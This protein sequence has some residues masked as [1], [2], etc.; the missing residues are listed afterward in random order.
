[1]S[2][3]V[4]YDILSLLEAK[5]LSTLQIRAVTLANSLQFD[6]FLYGMRI[7]S[8]GEK[9]KDFIL[10]SYPEGWW[11]TYLTSNY[12]EIDPVMKYGFPGML[13]YI[14]GRAESLNNQEREF[15]DDAAGHGLRTGVT[16]PVH[17]NSAE[18]GLLSLCRP[19]VRRA[20]DRELDANLANGQLMAI[21]LHEA[22]HKIILSPDLVKPK[23]VA[24]TPRESECLKWASAGKSAWDISF[25]LNISVN[26][27][28]F[29]FKQSYRKLDVSSR[30]HAV[31]KAIASGL[32]T[33]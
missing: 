7:T 4:F 26:T 20:Q 8:P 33:P 5:E 14:W 16:L 13:P 1:M 15:L 2:A 22:I 28:N 29:H 6:T 21:Y 18:S 19:D 25:I 17:K 27:V 11:N 32:L 23:S 31:A 3:Q 12:I 24:L 10:S 30:Q 9:V